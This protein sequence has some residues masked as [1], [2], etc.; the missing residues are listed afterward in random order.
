VELATALELSLADGNG[1]PFAG[2]TLVVNIKEHFEAHLEKKAGHD[3]MVFL[4][5]TVLTNDI[6]M[7]D[8]QRL[9]LSNL[10][11][12]RMSQCNSIHHLH[13]PHSLSHI[14]IIWQ[15]LQCRLPHPRTH[16]A[17]P[18]TKIYIHLLRLDQKPKLSLILYI[19][20]PY[21]HHLHRATIIY[22]PLISLHPLLV[23]SF[24]ET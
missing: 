13:F 22:I 11:N 23:H 24:Y 2:R 8:P 4:G 9:C 5:V 1:K 20:P 19:V 12:K 7:V 6:L 15:A 18:S 3:F 21:H 10:K 17:C 14:L 16:L